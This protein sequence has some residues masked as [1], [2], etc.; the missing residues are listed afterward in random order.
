MVVFQTRQLM[1]KSKVANSDPHL[2]V[3]SSPQSFSATRDKK[4]E[5]QAH[6]NSATREGLRFKSWPRNCTRAPREGCSQRGA[7]DKRARNGGKAPRTWECLYGGGG[8]SWEITSLH[9]WIRPVRDPVCHDEREERVIG[10]FFNQVEW[11]PLESID[12]A[13]L[14]SG[15]FCM[16]CK[17]FLLR[18]F[19]NIFRWIMIVYFIYLRM[20]NLHCF[21]K[22]WCEFQLIRMCAR[23]GSRKFADNRWPEPQIDRQPSTKAR[24]SKVPERS[25]PPASS[26]PPPRNHRRV[27]WWRSTIDIITEPSQS[28]PPVFQINATHVLTHTPLLEIER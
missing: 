6:C 20:I 18:S 8:G 5:A 27:S 17:N 21:E 14:L 24:K 4:N 19:T 16:E 2:F 28:A 1:N 3:T 12:E 26:F 25:C 22:F 23:P 9:V 15:T 13:L 7:A 10:W 11:G